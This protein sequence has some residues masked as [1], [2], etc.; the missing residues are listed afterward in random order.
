VSG[1]RGYRVPLPWYAL[2]VS[3]G[4]HGLA[5]QRP[6]LIVR[7]T[8]S[9][10]RLHIAPL[11]STSRSRLPGLLE[12]GASR[13]VFLPLRDI[14]RA[15]L[16]RGSHTPRLRPRR[17]TRPRRLAPPSA[18]RVC[19]TPLPRP[20]FSLQGVSLPRSRTASSAAVPSRR[21]RPLAARGCPPAPPAASPTSGPCSARESVFA[22]D[23]V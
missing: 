19:F 2:A 22:I 13:G 14:N 11:Q 18:L 5:A 20:G 21:C 23:G 7:R 10:S 3:D 8:G 16:P 12:P 4:A 6:R 9:S 15:Q 1:R 17:F